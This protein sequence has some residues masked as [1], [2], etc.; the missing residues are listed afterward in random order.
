MPECDECKAKCHGSDMYIVRQPIDEEE[1]EEAFCSETCMLRYCE[2]DI[3]KEIKDLLTYI[4]T[5]FLY[6]EQPEHIQKL[7]DKYRQNLK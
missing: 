2:S 3:I 7:Q 4:G 6:G 1:T 5:E